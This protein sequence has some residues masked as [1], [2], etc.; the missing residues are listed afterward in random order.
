MQWKKHLKSGG[1]E[2]WLGKLTTKCMHLALHMTSDA[3]NANQKINLK[4]L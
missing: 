4:W 1:K 2:E 3:P